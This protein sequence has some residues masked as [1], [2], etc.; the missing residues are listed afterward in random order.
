MAKLIQTLF[1]LISLVAT[2]IA[3]KNRRDDDENMP[4]LH[5]N[6]SLRTKAHIAHGTVISVAIVLFFPLGATMLR[7]SS[8]K[9]IV[10]W[11]MVWQMI[12]MFILFVGFGLGCWLSYLHNELW[13]RGHE[14]FGT[15]L[16]GLFFMQPLLGMLHHRYFTL[17]GKKNYKR[18][19]H[20]WLGRILIALGIINGGTGIKLAANTTSGA[21]IYGVIVGVVFVVYVCAWYWSYRHKTEGETTQS[22]SETRDPDSQVLE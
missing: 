14:V 18:D 4:G 20:V 1:L 7:L 12:G 11:H 3:A 16:V 17:T 5:G 10:W 13:N 19:L 6:E 2:C 15:V 8:S 21:I 9:N 22:S